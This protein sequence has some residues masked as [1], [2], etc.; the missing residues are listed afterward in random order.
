[1]QRNSR[2]NA[3]RYAIILR[4]A[5]ALADMLSQVY[6]YL[7]R[8]GYVV[9]RAKPPS[10]DY[11]VPPPFPSAASPSI[12]SR[13]YNAVTSFLS[14]VARIFTG[15]RDWWRPIC[16]NRWTHHNMDNSTYPQDGT[17]CDR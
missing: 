14:R 8:L 15:G 10:S 5:D 13:F 4:P 1:M 17:V 7:R 3:T 9:T 2:S 12:V 11:P 6:A 16:F